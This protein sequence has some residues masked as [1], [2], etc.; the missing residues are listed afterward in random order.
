[1]VRSL[2]GVP[3]KS[4]RREK[5]AIGPQ[6]AL[7]A[8][9]AVVEAVVEPAALL[10][11]DLAAVDLDPERVGLGF[12]IVGEALRLRDHVPLALGPAL[13][14][15]GVGEALHA[16]RLGLVRLGVRL[17]GL[18]DRF[19]ADPVVG[20]GER[21]Q[22]AE[23]GRVDHDRGAEAR[24]CRRRRGRARARRRSARRRSSTATVL[25]RRKIRSRPLARCGS[26]RSSIACAPTAGSKASRVTQQ[27]PGLKSGSGPGG[28]GA[29]AIVIAQSRCGARSSWRCLRTL[30]MCSCSSSAETP[31]ALS[32]PPSQSVSSSRQV[33]TP[34]PRRRQRRGDAARAAADD[35]HVAVDLA[36]RRR[37]RPPSAPP[38]RDRPRPAP[39]SRR[40][41]RRAGA[42]L[43]Y[44]AIVLGSQSAICG[45]AI[46][47]PSATTCKPM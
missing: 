2:L 11:V 23:L 39:A 16:M 24:A 40:R 5:P 44:L 31:W 35:E 21:Q 4:S 14:G 8:R 30:S 13:G 34:A 29:A 3:P 15:E 47:S 36:R 45:K 32:W 26:S 10:A 9:Q 41:S 1:M 22:V 27:S 42:P 38:R 20:A 6:A 46:T 12:A 43:R 28:A 7:G 25:V 17:A 37:G 18:G 33:R 19:G